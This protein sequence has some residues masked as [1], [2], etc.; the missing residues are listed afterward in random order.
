MKVAR[1]LD[2][3]GVER[4]GLVELDA[5]GSQTGSIV[6]LGGTYADLL[7]SGFST[8]DASGRKWP[9]E[10]VQLLPPISAHAKIFCVGFN[11]ASHG[12]EMEREIPTH[13]TLF[14]RYP[15]S[16]V[17]HGASV[18]R[19][20][21]SI[22]LDWEGEVGL[23]IGRRCRRAS[24]EDALSYV[25]GF[26]LVADNS[27]RDWQFHSTQA[28]AG[29]NWEASGACGPWLLT[30]DEVAG[31]D[32]VLET[33]LNG[34]RKQHESTSA[35]IFNFADLVTYIS[36]FVTLQPG[37]LI[38]TG[39]PSGIGYREDPPRFL[40]A[41]DQLKI[42]VDGIGSLINEVADESPDDSDV[43]T[44]AGVGAR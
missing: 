39:T 16:L 7:P 43:R 27:I 40:A 19:P 24:K 23:V 6:E 33:L 28:T 3:D 42:R 30:R 21:E 12:A 37:D 2:N 38:A 32:L 8:P 22:E 29:K 13:P 35:L 34:T 11:Y 15:E 44:E 9:L 36:S 31:R 10:S 1:Y 18:I 20:R 14:V 17:G 26:T 4:V 41:G 25:A 5:S